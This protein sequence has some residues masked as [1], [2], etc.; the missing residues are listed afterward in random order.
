MR[1]RYGLA[2]LIASIAIQQE[3]RNK[4][5]SLGCSVSQ[6]RLDALRAKLIERAKQYIGVPY[7]RKYWTQD[8][9]EYKSHLFLDCC[10]LVRRVVRDLQNDVGFR[11]GPW[12]Q[13]YMFDTLPV[14]L[15]IDQLKPGDLV[16]MT[17]IYNN[18]KSRR[19]HHNMVHVEIW[20]G[21]GHKTIGSRW[22]SGKVGIYDSY[23]FQPKSFHGEQYIFKSVDTWLMGVCRRLITSFC[24]E[25]KWLRFA[26]SPSSSRSIFSVDDSTGDERADYDEDSDNDA[27][28]TSGGIAS[29][30]A[31]ASDSVT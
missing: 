8:S 29:S 11:L 17:G 10:G 23:M 31:S 7:A 16:F 15:T 30:P 18:P 27:P 9:P 19:Q 21:D 24:T 28:S 13:A 5:S 4:S 14:T 26:V 3:R 25:H 6:E 12:N 2:S 20:L 1:A 22:N